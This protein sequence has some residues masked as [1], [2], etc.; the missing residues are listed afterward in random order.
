M[1]YVVATV[2]ILSYL[3]LAIQEERASRQFGPA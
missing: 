2:G 1:G 3:V